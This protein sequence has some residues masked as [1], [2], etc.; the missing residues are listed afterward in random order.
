LRLVDRVE[1]KVR[2]LARALE[3]CV[4]DSVSIAEFGAMETAIA[5]A[6]G[7]V[8]ATPLG[9]SGNPGTAIAAG[10]LGGQTWAFDAVYT[11][12]ETI[13][14]RD[15]RAAGLSI[16]SGYELF[17]FQGVHA[18]QLFSGTCPNDLGEL[19]RLLANATSDDK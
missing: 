16:L 11:P 3:N 8:N 17:F 13:F 15:A 4:G 5:G 7:I 6:D 10:L 12:V 19:R 18:F 9:M 14:V 2:S 1:S